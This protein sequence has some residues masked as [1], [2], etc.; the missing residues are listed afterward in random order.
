MC[1]I[2]FEKTI[3]GDLAKN[4]DNLELRPHEPQLLDQIGTAALEFAG[5]RFIRRRRAMNRRGDITILK[6]LTILA[7]IRVR[8]TRKARFMERRI[9]PIT[10]AIAGEHASCAIAA[11][12]RRRQ[13]D[14][15]QSCS[16]VAKT[17]EWF[18]PI[19]FADVAAWRPIGARFAPTN[20]SWTTA[21][22]DNRLV[23]SF[24]SVHDMI[25]LAQREIEGKASYILTTS[26]K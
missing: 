23:E 26:E 12:R 15:Q 22:S 1:L 7:I 6:F 11:V 10:A 8:V 21:A 24:Q 19:S 13:A 20:Q 17:G 2:S 14:D 9:E 16:A 5:T 18:G 3:E 25:G 4:D